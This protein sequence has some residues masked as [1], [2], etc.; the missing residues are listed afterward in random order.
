MSDKP[1]LEVL[2]EQFECNRCGVCCAVGGNMLLTYE[3]ICRIA[4]YLCCEPDDWE[5]IPV[6]PDALNPDKYRLMQDIPCFYLDKATMECTVQDA[7]PEACRNY[8]FKLLQDKGCRFNDALVCP[9]ARRIIA[10]HLGFSVE[11]M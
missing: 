6:K 8:P 11:Q 9:K 1:L 10:D 5:L 4:D 3:D 7:K 2:Q